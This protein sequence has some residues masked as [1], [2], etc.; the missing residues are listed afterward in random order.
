MY[1]IVI[2][3]GDYVITRYIS[4]LKILEELIKD[5]ELYEVIKVTKVNEKKRGK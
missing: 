2:K 3:V 5:N 1:Q 4:D